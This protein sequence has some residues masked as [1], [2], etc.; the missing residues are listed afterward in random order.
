MEVFVNERERKRENQNPFSS[1]F[2]LEFRGGG[3]RPRL[4]HF[5]IGADLV[6]FLQIFGGHRSV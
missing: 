1:V 3:T 4:L 2:Y 5:A 6:L